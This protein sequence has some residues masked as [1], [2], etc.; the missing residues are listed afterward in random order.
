MVKKRKAA[1]PAGPAGPKDV[2]PAD[3]RL[4]A[5]TTFE[6][7][8]DEQEQYFLDRD[9][10]L[11][12]E[13]PRSKRLRREE[14]E[15][16]FL[17]AS[18]EEVLADDDTD[19][20]EVDDKGAGRARKPGADEDYSD[21][22]R[23]DQEEEGDQGWWG[24]SRQEYYNADNIETEADALE[25]EVEARRLQQKKLSKMSE[26][27]FIFDEDE[28]A[29]QPDEGAAG[30]DTVTETLKDVEITDDVGPEERYRLLQA[31]YPEFD[32]LVDEFQELQPLL[33]VCQKDAEGKPSR[34][35][36]VAK[37]WIL[38]CY[39]AT[40]ASYFAIL[41]SPTRDGGG[42]Q[43]LLDASELRD[44]EI[45]STLVSCRQ[46][47]QKVQGLVPPQAASVVDAES[48]SE[49]PL[50]SAPEVATKATKAVVAAGDAAVRRKS[51]V[52][53]REKAAKAQA[54]E[55]S[56]ADLSGLLTKTRKP[57]KP[58]AGTTVAAQ[59]Q[60]DHSD[61]GEDEVLDAHAAADKASKKKTLRFYTSQIAQ[62]SNR[63]AGASRDAGGDMDI[64]YR[65]RLRDRQARLQAAAEK[66]GKKTG[67]DL[68]EGSDG[69]EEVTNGM[70]E[71]ADEEYYDMVNTASKK[72][73]ADKEAMYDA[74]AAAS[75][76]DRVVEKEEV[77]PDGKRRITYEIRE[78]KGLTP[79][80]KKDVRNPRVKKRKK[81]E[82]KKKKLAGLKP[83]WKGG[84]GKG[85][86]KGELTGIKAGLIKSIKL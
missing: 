15:D 52:A 78:N 26:A 67:A 54:I 25:E 79:K 38:G 48:A 58:H 2:D 14:A 4:G 63:R 43:R 40:L 24:S 57:S 83:V 16:D 86:Y 3:A 13:E 56:L 27:D 7:V 74:L 32:Y 19:E 82:E 46:A 60:D 35:L 31:R 77:G 81:W 61:F 66:R 51:K 29:G 18:D 69:E 12:E 45:M 36:E 42:S 76:A 84:E 75:K 80:R 85:G 37:H 53:D 10:I 59:A 22:E 70:R 11:L 34:S 21:E 17:E 55:E 8:A 44:H 30:E 1:R 41:T 5:I 6:D 39:V 68:G 73:K 49:E 9:K 72:R 33:H 47:W 28:W 23:G 64:P 20:E 71:G 62:K 50:E 65:E